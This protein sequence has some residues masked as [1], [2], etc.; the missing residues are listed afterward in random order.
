MSKNKGFISL[1]HSDTSDAS[2]QGIINDIKTKPSAY[3]E[4]VRTQRMLDLFSR[5]ASEVPAYKDFLKKQKLDPVKINTCEDF[6]LVPPMDKKNHLR[7]YPL[8]A[9]CWNGTVNRQFVFTST[10]GSTGDPFY[11]PRSAR[12]DWE[13]SIAHELFIGNSSYGTKEATLILVCFGMGVWIGGILTYKAFEMASARGNY[14]V[15]IL[16]PGINKEEIF[17]ALNLLAPHYRQVVL[18]GYPPFIKDIIDEAPGRGICLRDFHIRLFFAAE[19]FSE[20]FRDYVAAST[21]IENGCLD[22]LNIYGSADIG[23]MAYETPGSIFIRRLAMKR[24]PIFEK[25]FGAIDKTPTL[26]QYNPLFVS[27][28]AAEGEILITGDNAMPLVRYAIGDH[29]GIHSFSEVETTLREEGIDIRREAAEANIPLYELPFVHVY[30]RKDFSTTLY[31]LLIYPEMIREVFL[32]E[33]LS[34]FLTGRFTLITRFDEQ[35]NQFLEINI[36]L[37]K[38]CQVRRD[39]HDLTLKEIVAT[40]KEKSSEYSELF[41]HLGHRALPRIKL[42]PNGHP[43]H[44]LP[45]TKQQWVKKTII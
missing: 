20:A 34:L 28:E 36:E 16:T 45:G 13:A 9:L 23:T 19:S 42:W 44:F 43:D 33:P 38:G 30:E 14:P 4:R 26:C 8:H 17:K 12:L 1:S 25:L 35:Q 21:G 32:R 11:F 6:R 29:G 18:V 40:L 10:S 39:N 2:A 15:S 22:T 24:R 5:A 37:K 27:F 3:W 31:G 41:S 7:N